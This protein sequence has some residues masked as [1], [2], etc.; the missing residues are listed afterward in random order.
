M[1]LGTVPEYF[2][3]W[4]GKP[5]KVREWSVPQYG[6]KSRRRPKSD[7]GSRFYS[8]KSDTGAQEGDGT[9]GQDGSNLDDLMGLGGKGGRGGKDVS[10]SA[11]MT[12]HTNWVATNV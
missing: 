1:A 7:Y 12:L 3:F 9:E 6:R 5:L 2:N 10:S 11:V 4:Q 8:S